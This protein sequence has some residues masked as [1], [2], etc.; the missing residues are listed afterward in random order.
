MSLLKH[1]VRKFHHAWQRGFFGE[2]DAADGWQAMLNETSVSSGTLYLGQSLIE[3]DEPLVLP[4]QT[5]DQEQII[6]VFIGLIDER[7]VLAN[8]GGESM[9]LRPTVGEE[10]LPMVS[11][12]SQTYQKPMFFILQG[13]SLL[14]DRSKGTIAASR[15]RKIIEFY[16]DLKRILQ[17]S[18]LCAIVMEV[19]EVCVLLSQTYKKA[20]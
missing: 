3:V 5:N 16:L 20:L 8:S 4:R 18:S 7:L 15:N 9:L 17:G 19:P 11:I 2:N 6:S 14:L 12:F 10:I 13:C 1:Y